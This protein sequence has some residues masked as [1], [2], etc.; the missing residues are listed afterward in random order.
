MLALVIDWGIGGFSVVRQIQKKH[1]PLDMIYVSD[2]GFTPYGKLSK[3]AVR[4]RIGNIVDEA[5][6]KYKVDMVIIA[7]NAAST[8]F[9]G[10][11]KINKIPLINMIEPT[12]KAFRKMKKS[13]ITIVGGDLTAKSKSYSQLLKKTPHRVKE[14]SLQPL[15]ALIERGFIQGEKIEDILRKRLGRLQ[16]IKPERPSYLVLACTHYPAA[17]KTFEKLFQATEVLDPAIAVS[18]RLK[19]KLM[20]LRKKVKR[21]AQY[22]LLQVFTTGTVKSM[23]IVLKKT[24]NLDLDS[25]LFKKFSL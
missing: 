25:R 15:S 1:L 19:K 5:S 12:A 20:K 13:Q 8:A 21:K 6:K 16:P 9:I 14:I 10:K 22:K 4:E 7:C 17:Q 18:Y 11:T 3:K 23:P 2:S 24:F